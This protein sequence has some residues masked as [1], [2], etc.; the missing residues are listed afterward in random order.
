MNNDQVKQMVFDQHPEKWR[1][2]YICS[3]KSLETDLL[4]DIAQF[5][6]N[7]KGFADCNDKNKCKQQQ[8]NNN[9]NFGNKKKKQK[10][11]NN[12]GGFRQNDQ[13]KGKWDAYRGVPDSAPC[14]KHGSYHTSGE[15]KHNPFK[16]RAQKGEYNQ[17]P[18][19]GKQ[20]QQG[21]CD[22]S[23]YQGQG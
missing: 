21:A 18:Y 1:K 23:Q 15:C 6:S 22:G 9:G 20:R 19:Q 4:A 11:H 2:S 5:K 3:G 13:D 7:K 10:Y 12:K 17:N 16:K 14:P 8:E